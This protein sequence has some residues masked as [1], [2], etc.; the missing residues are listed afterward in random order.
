MKTALFVF[1]LLL[2]VSTSFSQNIVKLYKGK[3]PG[4]ESWTWKEATTGAAGSEITYNVVEPELL[5]YLAP[6]EKAN[7]TAIIIAPGGAFHILSTDNEGRAVAKWLNEKG[8]TAFVLKYRVVRSM[9]NNPIQELMPKM[10]DFKKLDSINAPVVEMATQDGIEAIKYI[11]NNAST[12]QIDPGKIGFMGFSAGGTVT[13]SVLMSAPD[14]W[15]PNF[16]A[17]IYLKYDVVVGKMMPK[18]IT[19]LFVAVASDDQLGF[20][21]HSINL[22]QDWIKAK[23]PAE[24]HIYERGGHGFGMMKHNTSSD[25][26]AAD[27]ENWLKMRGYM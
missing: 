3:A 12:Y 8:I 2:C 15:K 14:E 18:S 9:T 21:P 24:L 19:P 13:V 5:V 22:Y 1:C 27:F 10:S 6:K 4:S 7:G 23:Q 26:W 11:R 20:M 16:A 25:Q 17:P